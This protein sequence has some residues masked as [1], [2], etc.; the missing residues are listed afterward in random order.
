[1]IKIRMNK[2]GK[3]GAKRARPHPPSSPETS[4]RRREFSLPD[5][6]EDDDEEFPSVED[7]IARSGSGGRKAKGK[8]RKEGPKAAEEEEAAK[9]A[10]TAEVGS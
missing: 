4:A 9:E 2:E 8:A 10:K 1:M 3:K 6:P 7:I 5:F